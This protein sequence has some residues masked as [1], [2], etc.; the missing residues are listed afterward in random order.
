[1]PLEVALEGSVLDESPA[2]LEAME[3]L[4]TRVD[5]LV[6]A[7]VGVARESF[8][9]GDARVGFFARVDTLVLAEVPV[10]GE[11]LLTLGALV[12]PFTRMNLLVP[13]QMVR[14]REGGS[15]YGTFV[16]PLAGMNSYVAPQIGRIGKRLSTGIVGT[17][18]RFFPRVYPQVAAKIVPSVEYLTALRTQVLPSSRSFRSLC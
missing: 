16:R 12:W 11:R 15:A 2:A 17:N 7:E 13:D 1:M 6:D 8:A 10:V 18:E 3:G 5:A 14:A 9:A 4:L